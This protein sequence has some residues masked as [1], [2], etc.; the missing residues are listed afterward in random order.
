MTEPCAVELFVTLIVGLTDGRARIG[1]KHMF[2]KEIAHQQ[3]NC[4]TNEVFFV[5]LIELLL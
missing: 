3:W 2:E 1:I 4:S 5:L